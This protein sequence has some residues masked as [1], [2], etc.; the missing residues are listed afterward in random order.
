MLVTGGLQLLLLLIGQDITCDIIV[1]SYFCDSITEQISRKIEVDRFE[2]KGNRL[3]GKEV[4]KPRDYK[5]WRYSWRIDG[6]KWIRDD[7]Q[8]GIL[9]VRE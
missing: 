5:R 9:S 7:V 4:W 8:N 3:R 6:Q 2:T 1:V